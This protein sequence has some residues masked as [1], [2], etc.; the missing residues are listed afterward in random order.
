[1]KRALQAQPPISGRIS[2]LEPCDRDW[3]NTMVFS[4]APHRFRL[5]PGADLEWGE[6]FAWNPRE[7][8]DCIAL[9]SAS[10][11]RRLAKLFSD[12]EL[13]ETSGRHLVFL[14]EHGKS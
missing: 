7:Q 14:V 10:A 9:W 1:M 5:L 8:V 11:R 13:K 4:G 2:L 6:K 12:W 3:P